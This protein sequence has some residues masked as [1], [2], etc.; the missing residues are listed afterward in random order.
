M[1]SLFLYIALFISS[2]VSAIVTESI[3][4]VTIAI[5]AKDKSHTLP[6]YLSCIE[7]QT[8]PASKTY[9]YIRTNN[10]NDS[11]STLLQEWVNRVQHKYAGIHFDATDVKEPVQNYKQHE[12]NYTRFKVLGKIRQDSVSWALKHTSHYFVADC[13]NFIKPHTIET[14]MK[15]NLP[16]VAPLLHTYNSCYSNYHAAV[17]KNGYYAE[18]PLYE[19]FLNQKI[20][21]LVEVPVVHCTY[22]IRYEFLDKISYDDE[23][24]RYEYV[25]FSD[26][27]RKNSIPQYLDTREIYGGITFAEN[28]I[29]ETEYTWL[30]EKAGTFS[31]KVKT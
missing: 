18:S 6:L 12:W 15:S 22:F 29:H 30:I 19:H 20:K 27:A 23:S 5:L 25:I 11:T 14:L 26:I 1:K 16:I 10:N 17:D 13:D 21:G 3:D 7:Q 8:W 28:T 2:I 24:F 4:Y 9:L 31:I